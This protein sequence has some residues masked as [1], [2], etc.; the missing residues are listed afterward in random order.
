MTI[1]NL[2]AVF[3]PASV[4][5]IGASD[6]VGSLGRVITQ[7]LLADFR[8]P[9]YLVNPK[10]S[11]LFGHEVFDDVSE[12][13]AAPDLAV[14]AT[15]PKT[16]PGLIKKLV[17]QGTRGACVITAGLGQEN[18]RHGKS[19]RQTMLDAAKPGLLRIVGPNCL[20]LQ[21]PGIG[22]NASF[23]HLFPPSGSIAFIAQSGALLTAM[24]DWAQPKGIG[25]SHIVSIGEMAD[26][27]FGDMLDY[28]A[29]ARETRAILLYVESI[30][31]ARKFMSA[32][33]AAARSKPVIVVKAGRFDAGARAASSHTGAMAGHDGVYDAAFRRAGM[34]RVFTLEELFDAVETLATA[35][36]PKGDRLAILTNG[37]GIGVLAVDA[38]MAEGGE[39]AMLSETTLARLDAVLPS[40][41][42][43]GNP[44]DIV[45]DAGG[46]RYRDALDVLLDDDDCDAVLILNCPTAVTSSADAA[47]AVIDAFPEAPTKPVFTAWVGAHTALA[48]RQRFREHGIPSYDSPEDAVHAFSQMVCYRHNQLQLAET[49]PSLPV[50]FEPDVALARAQIDAAL[51]E[52]RAWLSEA[53]SKR[54]LEAYGIPTVRTEIAASTEEV[55]ALAGGFDGPVAI[56][57]LSPDITHKSDVGG[58]LLDV[59]PQLAEAAAQGMLARVLEASPGAKIQGFTVQAMVQRQHA[60]ELIAGMVEDRQ[61]GPVIL[62]GHGG[63]AVEVLDDKALS[64]PP[65]NLKLA[66]ELIER[67]DVHRLLAGYRQVPAADID[68]IALSL[69]RLS[70]LIVEFPEIKELDINPLLADSDGVQALDARVKIGAALTSGAGRLA[71]RPYPKELEE[72]FDAGDGRTLQLRPIMPEDEPSLQAAFGRLSKEE[73]RNRFFIPMKLLDHVMAARFTQIDYD[74]HMAL[75][76]AEPGI[77]GKTEIFAV[78]RLTEDPDR[79]RAEFAIVVDGRLA[80]RGIGTYLVRRVLDYARERGIA[81]VC[82]DVLADNERMLKLCR[83]LGFTLSREPE[84]PD[85]VRVTMALQ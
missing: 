62:F 38:L 82:G 54:L 53:E 34:L 41:W 58:V 39:L 49:P 17:K 48:Q 45:G 76:L 46:Q 15:P 32:A 47:Q 79:T 52:N 29:N 51:G 10:H 42:S 27:D 7:N 85:I 3:Q 14:I 60:R 16:V 33:R 69:V 1:R 70:H 20:G 37:G 50:L 36:L 12:L 31:D 23:A 77:P 57:I 21:V 72:N 59:E 73:V 11:T 67:T 44:V 43:H 84:S 22:L 68:A 18:G 83:R 65:L 5:I 80:G 56:K 26:V 66:R 28:L 6:R 35:R 63:T 40:T 81:V 64:L 55:G 8:G 24:L 9:I 74:R 2:D 61:F 25:F 75:V 13:P 4:A 19:L 71:I 30:T 78:V